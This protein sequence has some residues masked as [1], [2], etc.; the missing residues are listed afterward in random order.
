MRRAEELDPFSRRVRNAKGWLYLWSGQPDR[1][2]QQAQTMLE[3]ERDFAPAHYALGLAYIAAGK[4]EDAIVSH[5][6]A[7]AQ[8]GESTRSLAFLAHALGKAGQTAEALEIIAGLTERARHNYVAGYQVAIAYMGV[9]NKEE[10]LRWLEYAFEQRAELGNLNRGGAIWL[11]ALHSDP[12][13]Q[14]LLRRLR[15]PT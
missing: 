2:V 9:D 11:R 14:D 4:Y 15:L 6:R 1:A 5:R 12:R 7:I 13:Y 10:A 3:L 8:S